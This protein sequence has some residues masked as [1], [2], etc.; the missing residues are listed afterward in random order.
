MD[1]KAPPG[2][3]TPIISNYNTPKISRKDNTGTVPDASDQ[4]RHSGCAA[5]PRDVRMK[6]AAA[7]KKRKTRF[8]I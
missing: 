3:Q 4:S 1:I 6:Y 7:P 5:P 8:K 2:Q